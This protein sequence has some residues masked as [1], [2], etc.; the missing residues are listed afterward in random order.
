MSPLFTESRHAGP[1]RHRPVH[2]HKILR[3][4]L[5]IGLALAAPVAAAGARTVLTVSMLLQM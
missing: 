4:L 1:S 5:V 3:L 2:S